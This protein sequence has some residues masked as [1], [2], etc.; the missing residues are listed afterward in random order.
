MKKLI[1][2][3]TLIILG[4]ISSYTQVWAPVGAKWTY[5]NIS[6]GWE[7]FY[8]L[9]KTIECTGDT[10]IGGKSCRIFNGECLC[11]F[12]PGIEFL[13]YEDDKVYHYVDSVVGFT[14]LYNFS[15]MPGESWTCIIRKLWSYD[16][17]IFEVTGLGNE[18]IGDDTIPFQFVKTS[19]DGYWQWGGKVYKYLGDYF[20]FYPQYATADPWTGPI[21]CYEDSTIII[22]F[23]DI[24]C[25]TSMFHIGVNEYVL[26]NSIMIFP[27]PATSSI[28]INKKEGVPIE[29]AIIYNHL[30]QKVLET[31]PVN[32]TVDVSTLKPGIYFIE[33]ATKE[34][35]GRTKLIIE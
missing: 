34:W 3:L 26:D 29:E 22:K 19:D 31:K 16:T 11:T 10:I 5:S 13:Y 23:Q 28:T 21:R 24:P 25:D 4:P 14:M 27:N 35:R 9:P 30:A 8:N 17:T 20:C 18:I 2:F 33:V 12:N 1:L 6:M 32:N 15:A 7:P